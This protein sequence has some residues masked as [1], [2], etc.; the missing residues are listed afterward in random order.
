MW[1][2]NSIAKKYFKRI[3]S[4][5]KS[6][7]TKLACI[8]AA[9]SEHSD[10]CADEAKYFTWVLEQAKRL[11]RVFDFDSTCNKDGVN[12]NPQYVAEHLILLGKRKWTEIQLEGLEKTVPDS[13]IRMY[14]VSRLVPA[15]YDFSHNETENKEGNANE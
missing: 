1:A 14:G 8:K 12:V 4:S 15:E 9:I 10:L 6:T 2:V 3:P 13:D 11:R 7:E 5:I